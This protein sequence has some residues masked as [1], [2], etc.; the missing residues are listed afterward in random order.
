MTTIKYH[1]DENNIVHLTIDKPNSSVN[2]MDLTFT[3]DLSITIAQLLQDNFDGVI[4]RSNKETFFVGGDINMLSQTNESNV[5]ELYQMVESLKKSMRQLETTGKPVVACINGA[6]LGGGFELALACHHR[7]AMNHKKVKLGLPEVTLGL[8]PGAGGITRMVRLLGLNNS[9]PYLTLGNLFDAEKGQKLGLI[10][11]LVDNESELITNAIKWIKS[12]A[13]P[14]YQPWDI[15]GYKI[16]GGTPKDV[17]VNQKLPI[18]PTMLK[19]P[20]NGTL[21]APTTI[22]SAMVEGS[23]VDFDSAGKI[24][25]GYFVELAKGKVSSN[26]I[27]TFWT[28]LNEIHSSKNRPNNIPRFT[29]S[30]IA[31][32]GASL[33]GANIAHACSIK[34]IEVVLKSTCVKSAEEGKIYSSNLLN[35][36]LVN[37]YI[38]QEEFNNALA[39]ITPSDDMNDLK[40]CQVIIEAVDENTDIEINKDNEE[41]ISKNIIFASNISTLSVLESVLSY[42][43]VEN[44]IG[45]FFSSSTESMPLV[46]II[47]GKKSCP[48][49]LALCYDFSLQ[50]GKT[51]IFV[52]NSCGSF[53]SRLCA[54]YA[55]E[56]VS[57]LEDAA[58]ASIENAAYLNG[59]LTGPLA[60]TDEI[61]LPLIAAI[62]CEDKVNGD[63]E[64]KEYFSHP[65]DKILKD[66]IT[67]S[68]TGKASAKGFYN[69]PSED[70]KHLWDNLKKYKSAEVTITLQDIKDRLLFIMSIETVRCVEEGIL[71]STGDAN[72]GSTYGT[73]YPKW[74]GGTLQFINQYGLK[75]FV[76][77]SNELA[78]RYGKRFKVPNLLT[79]M[80]KANKL[81]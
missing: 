50:L 35:K 30:K 80:A 81:F 21:P 31:V 10:H 19:T 12:Q 48:R 34:G 40:D 37:G 77:R 66:M 42:E 69:Y 46:E 9:M 14:V 73:G 68:R 78:S 24:E 32:V 57:L 8:L 75:E 3:D 58:A 18:T 43:D 79:N 74:T 64:G 67:K 56:G 54:T 22:L 65:A 5:N 26:I 63:K 36:Q 4:L 62:K 47:C 15:K 59:F 11:Q 38:N 45:L 49:A 29:F 33:I 13:E 25:S 41:V 53:T 71:V 1:K 44:H 61:A 76:A 28:Q 16:P 72:I 55:K 27:N 7:I 60:V 39:L 20:S 6:A 51:P 70:K 52:K 2:L 17:K 23:Q